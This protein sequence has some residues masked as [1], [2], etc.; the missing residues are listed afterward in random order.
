MVLHLSEKFPIL[1]K[2]NR[3]PERSREFGGDDLAE[4][5]LLR[6]LLAV[7]NTMSNGCHFYPCDETAIGRHKK[8]LKESAG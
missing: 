3:L 1:P 2:F 7:V 5:T 4:K 8:Y 6:A